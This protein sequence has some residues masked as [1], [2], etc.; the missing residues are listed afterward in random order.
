MEVRFAQP[1]NARYWTQPAGQDYIET[2][3]VTIPANATSVT[4]ELAAD[5]VS[6]LPAGHGVFTGSVTAAILDGAGIATSSASTASVEIHASAVVGLDM[7]SYEVNESDGTLE[8][9]LLVHNRGGT[10]RPDGV[11][12]IKVT[13]L[14]DAG[15][16][17]TAGSDFTATELDLS[18]N[19][20][21]IRIDPTNSDR[22]TAQV[23]VSIPLLDDS[24]GERDET[25]TL[26]VTL[27]NDIIG[28]AVL[29]TSTDGG[30]ITGDGEIVSCGEACDVTVTIAGHAETTSDSTLVTNLS[31]TRN[32]G[33]AGSIEAQRFFTGPHPEGYALTRVDL[34]LRDSSGRTSTNDYVQIWTNGNNDR[35][36]SLVTELDRPSSFNDDVANQFPVKAGSPTVLQ[37][38]THYWVVVNDEVTHSFRR[39]RLA[40]T[41][42][43]A[44]T[45]PADPGWSIANERYFRTATGDDWTYSDRSLSMRIVGRAAGV[46][47]LSSLTA[48]DDDGE[49]LVLHPEFDPGRTTHEI[50]VASD[51]TKVRV[52]VTTTD[53]D[54][55]VT[56]QDNATPATP[57]STSITLSTSSLVTIQTITVTGSDGSATRTHTLRIIKATPTGT[58]A[59]LVAT[60]AEGPHSWVIELVN[61][62]NRSRF[63]TGPNATGYTVTSL[64]LRGRGSVSG[65]D[66][67]DTFVEIYDRPPHEAGSNRIALANPSSFTEDDWT[68]FTFPAN[69]VLEP[70]SN[71]WLVVN[72][73]VPSGNARFGHRNTSE[74]SVDRDSA[75]GWSI[76]RGVIEGPGI[77]YLPALPLMDLQG[78]PNAASGEARLDGLS[79]TG[80][81]GEAVSLS[82][83]FDRDTNS[84]TASVAND[85]HSVTIVA[86]ALHAEAVISIEGDDDTSTPGEATVDLDVGTKTIRVTV[87]AQDSI[88]REVYE[89]TVTRSALDGV[90]IGNLNLPAPTGDDLVMAQSFTT[91]AAPGEVF[92][93]TGVSLELGAGNST[94]GMSNPFVTVNVDNGSEPGAV[95]GTLRNPSR[96]LDEA[97]NMFVTPSGII[98]EPDTTYWLV[99]NEQSGTERLTV[100]TTSDDGSVTG[101]IG[102]GRL[103]KQ[104]ASN[105]SWTSN[106]RRVVFAVHGVKGADTRTT[107]F[108]SLD[109][110]T[111]EGEPVV[112]RPAEHDAAV[113]VYEA[114]VDS[115]TT[116][117][118]LNVAPETNGSSIDIAGDTDPGPAGK[119]A[120]NVAEGFNAVA[121]TVDSGSAGSA[122]YTVRIG[123]ARAVTSAALVRNTDEGDSGTVDNE[124]GGQL[125]A[126]HQGFHTG[127]HPDGYHLEGVGLASGVNA[128]YPTDGGEFTVDLHELNSD[129]SLGAFVFRLAN[130]DT[131]TTDSVNLFTA[132]LG[133]RPTRTPIT[134]SGW[135][136][137]PPAAR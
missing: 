61:S 54:A 74:I 81:F 44:E 115:D 12:N 2:R 39:I 46:T 50:G 98:L 49:L 82:P 14:A 95:V 33:Q 15:D 134:P 93:V 126:I 58:A 137:T 51:E 72:R 28:Q 23:P 123:R 84:Y 26:R 70:K 48:T 125:V 18:V 89:V 21:D 73:A 67:D 90:L 120:L 97:T 109:V 104:T 131:L 122:T 87:T 29:A 132:P 83:S 110:T 59:K 1:A 36:G 91:G 80:A 103:T 3:T 129:G 60:G 121:F 66:P 22:W 130:P 105:A 75:F 99:V 136:R 20:Q 63:S 5:Y 27:N 100:L 124:A 69:T 78:Y 113:S 16:T 10:Q 45:T 96:L 65:L 17:A 102:S 55:T 85:S 68:T 77:Y 13:A 42:H 64:A 32:T 52:T 9:T 62:V 71:Y 114:L 57:N 35:P 92:T 88:S 116:G 40:N 25:F 135:R 11:T 24:A 118:V 6:F 101:T 37:P 38:D 4:I 47:T 79:V 53:P 108:V 30:A 119:V 94:L 7:G 111:S 41:S 19:P 112:V 43:D 56:I 106:E 128:T 31:E 76:R 107:G 133:A 127:D 34:W 8:A 86:A 117:V